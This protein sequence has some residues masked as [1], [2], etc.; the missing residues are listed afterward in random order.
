[1]I[2]SCVLDGATRPSGIVLEFD[3]DFVPSFDDLDHR[4]Y[5][6]T[7]TVR[8]IKVLSFRKLATIK[9]TTSPAFHSE[10]PSTLI[11]T[12]VKSSGAVS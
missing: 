12:K 5:D 4:L 8:S 11:P 3:H 9:P 10:A 1:M 6:A 7:P 2:D